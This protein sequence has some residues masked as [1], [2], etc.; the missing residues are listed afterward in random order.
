MGFHVSCVGSMGE[1]A[2]TSTRIWSFALT[3]NVTPAPSGYVEAVAPSDAGNPVTGLPFWRMLS[4]T[5]SE[6]D[7]FER[8]PVMTTVPS[9]GADHVEAGLPARA[10][11][12]P[13]ENW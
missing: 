11:S 12:E 2:V 10:K 8:S 1:S 3:D 7:P 13:C 9:A 5:L 4:V 6:V